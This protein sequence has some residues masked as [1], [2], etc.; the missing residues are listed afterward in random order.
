MRVFFLCT[1]SSPSP[2]RHNSK[3]CGGGPAKRAFIAGT[4]TL[5]DILQAEPV[6][7]EAPLPSPAMVITQTVLRSLLSGSVHLLNSF[8][9][10]DIS[11]AMVAA[12]ESVAEIER[13]LNAITDLKIRAQQ[14]QIHSMQV[15][16]AN[17]RSQLSHYDTCHREPTACS[18]DM[19][20]SRLFN[21]EQQVKLCSESMQEHRNRIIA[22]ERSLGSFGKLDVQSAV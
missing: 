6:K 13:E 8:H 9:E 16:V 12:A 11:P 4:L 3:S 19:N 7:P 14:I 2:P 21:I 22:V 5:K 15:E 1:M 17:L 18:M 10:N 20:H